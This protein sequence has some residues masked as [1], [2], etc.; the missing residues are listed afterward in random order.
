MENLENR[1][2]EN[3][4]IYKE[5]NDDDEIISE[6]MEKEL[7]IIRINLE[8]TEKKEKDKVPYVSKFDVFFYLTFKNKEFVFQIKSDLFDLNKNYTYELIQN[9]IKKINKKKIIIN[10]ENNKY[11]ISL[12][13]IEDYEDKNKKDF[14]IQNYE[15]KKCNKKNFF[16]K[17]DS[18][19]FSSKV[20]LNNITSKQISLIAKSPLNIMFRAKIETK[21]EE[22][23]NRYHNYYDDE[24]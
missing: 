2:K 10:C 12:K 9:I 18:I 5:I 21:L 14:Y 4:D 15:L 20:L 11:I 7:N 19:S 13:D 23:D 17:M 22:G 24:I 3:E 8:K 16:P 1:I 6:E